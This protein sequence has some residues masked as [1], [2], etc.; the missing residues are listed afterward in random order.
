MSTYLGV[1]FLRLGGQI[2]PQLGSSLLVPFIPG[3]HKEHSFW[4]HP[5]EPDIRPRWVS[6]SSGSKRKL[7]EPL[8]R[9]EPPSLHDETERATAFDPGLQHESKCSFVWSSG[10]M[11]F[12]WA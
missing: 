10:A 9:E 1:F 12:V 6:G 7:V 8:L 4:S 2:G 3:L 11:A 5:R